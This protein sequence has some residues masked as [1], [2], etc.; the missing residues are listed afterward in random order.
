MKHAEDTGRESSGDLKPNKNKNKKHK[1][2][3]LET[4]PQEDSEPDRVLQ[5]LLGRI[6]H[7]DWCGNPKCP[8]SSGLRRAGELGSD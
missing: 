5:H 1:H 3:N 2:W 6:C 4:Q 7:G 8:A